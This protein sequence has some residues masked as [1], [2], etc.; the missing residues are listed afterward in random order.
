MSTIN[1]WAIGAILII[2]FGMAMTI[3]YLDARI[4]VL[5]Q[6]SSQETAK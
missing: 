6:A 2:M 5:E 1:S 3:Q 4:D